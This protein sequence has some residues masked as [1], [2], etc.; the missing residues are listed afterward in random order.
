MAVRSSL[1][2]DTWWHLRAGQWI[3]EN[4]SVPQVDHFSYTRM[5]QSWQYPGWLTEAPLYLIYKFTGPSGLNLWTAIIV[6]LA[7][8]FVYLTLS[9]G[10]FLRAFVVILSAA[11]SAIYWAARPHLVTFLLTA[12]YLWVLEG[13]RWNVGVRQ[14]VKRRLWWLPLLMVIWANSH[15]GFIVGFIIT[16][17]YIFEAV[18]RWIF[19]RVF[20]HF[21]R[22]QLNLADNGEANIDLEIDQAKSTVLRLLLTGLGMLIAVCLNPSGPIMLLYPFK[23]VSIGS[24]S[25]YIQ[26]WQPPDFHSAQVQPFIWLI[27]ITFG[28]VGISRRRIATSDLLLFTGFLY[29]SFNA[30]RNIALFALA[31]APVLSRYANGL[32]D[33]LSQYFMVDMNDLKNTQGKAWINWAIFVVL[34]LGVIARVMMASL[35]ENN[36]IEIARL[37]PVNAVEEIKNSKPPGRLFNSYNWGGYLLYELPEYPVFIDGRTDIYDDELVYEWLNIYQAKPGW[38]QLLD[39]WGVRLILIEPSSPLVNQLEQNGWRL[40]YRDQ[41]AVLYQR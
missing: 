20:A 11:T 9:G 16:G 3:V 35:P 25:Q 39:R 15:G 19:F 40:A 28:I 34:M 13:Y 14:T 30:A 24:L 38:Q 26:E 22:K 32:L 21:R 6:T 12:I 2:S 10:V 27:L 29:L 8:A 4:L 17:I 18:S 33:D 1:D 36:W 37:M 31:A 7:F 23:T 5:G 41:I